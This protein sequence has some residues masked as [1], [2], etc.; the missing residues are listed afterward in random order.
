M[1]RTLCSSSLRAPSNLRIMSSFIHVDQ[2]CLLCESWPPI[3]LR[4]LE[5]RSACHADQSALGI[6][7]YPAAWRRDN[8]KEN[9][10]RRE[11]ETMGRRRLCTHMTTSWLTSSCVRHRRIA[12]LS[13][14]FEVGNTLDK[15]HD[16]VPHQDFDRSRDH[17]HQ[18]HYAHRVIYA[19]ATK[20]TSAANSECLAPSRASD[21][22]STER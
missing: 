1:W 6:V 16:V 20:E 2:N 14:A 15:K 8:N 3:R 18:K 13:H 11:C 10:K 4:Y 5:Q 7:D 17:L 9:E 12:S 21:V 22:R 19:T